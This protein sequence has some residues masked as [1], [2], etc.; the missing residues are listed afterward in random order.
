MGLAHVQESDNAVLPY[1]LDATCYRIH[2]LEL[3]LTSDV[4]GC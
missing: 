4:S 1:R 3:P 2:A